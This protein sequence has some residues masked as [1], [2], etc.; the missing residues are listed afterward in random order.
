MEDWAARCIGQEL[1]V[2]VK[3]H[4]DN[5]SPGMYDLTLAYPDRPH[6]AAEVTAAADEESVKL[7]KLV[8]DGK[9]WIVP[10]I[11]GGWSAGLHP[12]ANFKRIRQELPALLQSLESQG[13]H[14][15][16]PEVDWEPGPHKEAIRSLGVVR[17]AQH[18]TDFPGAVYLNVEQDPERTGGLSPTD[19]RPLLDWLDVWLARPDKA[20]NI[21]KLAASNA[22]ERH[23]FLILPSFADAPFGVV[24]MLIRDDSPLPDTSPDLPPG[25][26]HLWMLSTWNFSSTGI[27]WS[28][29]D[30]WSRFVKAE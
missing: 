27:R 2:D 3:E 23:L 21:A 13:I 8:Y 12:T 24:D 10:D 18:G 25:V 15:P 16:Q 7:G 30:G 4:D 1:N 9:R 5:S 17:L 28:P 20:D 11:A 29:D 19:G 14:D 22:D 6:G 26:T